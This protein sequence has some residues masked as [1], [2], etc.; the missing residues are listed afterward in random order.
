MDGKTISQFINIG[1]WDFGPQDRAACMVL[2]RDFEY[3]LHKEF[4]R[5]KWLYA[6]TY[7]TEDEFW[8]IYD[9]NAY[10]TLRKKY[11]ASTLPSVYEK[12]KVDLEETS[13]KEREK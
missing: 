3:R 4:D 7:Y 5:T 9:K 13:R 10:D 1:L 2:N 12:V 11:R 6:H 8:N